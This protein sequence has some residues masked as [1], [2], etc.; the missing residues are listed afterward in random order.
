MGTRF[1]TMRDWPQW[2]LLAAVFACVLIAQAPLVLNPGYFSH[3]E[4]QWAA[5]A[6]HDAHLISRRNC[7]RTCRSS[8]IGR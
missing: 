3:D 6:G 4:L 5:F 7:G 8:S 1:G 2:M